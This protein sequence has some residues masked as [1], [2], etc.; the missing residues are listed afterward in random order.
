M[1]TMQEN[2]AG[3]LLGTMVGDAIGLPVEG[4]DCVRMAEQLDRFPLLPRGEQELATAVL[5]LITGG[6]V[7]AGEA[8]YSDDT[9]MAI[10]VAQ[11]LVEEGEIVPETLA[12]RFATNFQ[13]WRGYGPGAYGVLDALKQGRP[14]DEPARQVFG[15]RGS[16]GNGAAM[17][18]AP[19]GA[20]F[21]D[22]D[23]ATIRE[24]ARLSSLPTHTHPHGIEGA[25]VIALAVAGVLR[26]V[27]AGADELDVTQ[28]L[29]FIRSGTH[30]EIF[31]KKLAEV[32]GFLA[33]EPEPCVVAARLGT[34]L[35]ATLS[36]PAALFAFLSRWDS[37][38]D[39]ILYAVRLGGDADTIAAMAGALAGAFHGSAAIPES[40]LAA[41][42]NGP[43]G[44]DFV[45]ALAEGLYDRWEAASPRR[46]EVVGAE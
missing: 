28:L 46:L 26:Q 18:V 1:H 45:R 24:Q 9:Q 17:R 10:S 29:G 30:D 13:P 8:R 25:V 7:A 33:A 21:W 36:V 32:E 2:F 34:D 16:Y 11:I 27:A 38:P 6:K 19:V 35:T 37:L 20:F 31:F 12:R 41:L 44:R 5:G 3:M 43:Q 15:G 23:V 14:W 4:W 22:S 42:E 39:C 40:W